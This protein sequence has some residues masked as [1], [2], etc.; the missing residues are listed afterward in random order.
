MTHLLT[1]IVVLPLLGAVLNGLFATRLRAA[2][3][4]KTFVTVIGCGL[5][6][7]SCQEFE[8]KGLEVS[9]PECGKF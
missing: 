7:L 9:A 2:P 6:I 8:E 5:P 4:G 3:L 1:L